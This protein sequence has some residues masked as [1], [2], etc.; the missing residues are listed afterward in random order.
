ML[1]W[2]TQMQ[3]HVLALHVG[4]PHF[5][6]PSHGGRNVAE[7]F[8]LVAHEVPRFVRLLRILVI[9]YRLELCFHIRDYPIS[10]FHAVQRHVL[11]PFRSLQLDDK[12]CL[13]IRGAID[14]ASCRVL[15]ASMVPEARWLRA[16]AW[17]INDLLVSISILADEAYR[18]G[19]FGCARDKYNDCQK[20]FLTAM[21]L[22]HRLV[23]E[24]SGSIHLGLGLC[25]TV[26]VNAIICGLQLK[27][28]D[29]VIDQT[30]AASLFL[31]FH[32]TLT[33]AEVS[34]A[35]HCRS[36]ALASRFKDEE[37][38]EQLVEAEKLDP[39]SVILL[40]NLR[41]TQ[42]R[43]A[44]TTELSKAA[45]G[46]IV[47]EESFEALDK[48]IPLRP[49]GKEPC[50]Y[51]AGERFLMRHYG[52]V[53]PWLDDIQETMPAEL[54]LMELIIRET[55]VE[56]DAIGANTSCK[57]WV[58]DTDWLTVAVCDGVTMRYKN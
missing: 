21:D 57:L 23:D 11:E 48:T 6:E 49:P 4:F 52:Y 16:Q 31:V 50:E 17:D 43:L 53:G 3:K 7:S 10:P 5:R 15:R 56:R 44:A 27:A 32:E 51:I 39:G 46:T 29:Y 1:D 26:Y 12:E 33:P 13:I 19:D 25:A 37:A 54:E 55:K 22:N 18:L 14:T 8:L 9:K 40:E 47:R 45:V 41:I 30:E 38:C 20:L 35:R 2:L 36:I 42:Q 24:V 34:L 28:Y 58:G